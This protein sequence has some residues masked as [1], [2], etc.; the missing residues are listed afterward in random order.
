MWI[1]SSQT[2]S[3]FGDITYAVRLWALMANEGARM[4]HLRARSHFSL[5]LDEPDQ[6]CSH[7]DYSASI[8]YLNAPPFILA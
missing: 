8:C 2:Q 1:S 5:V 6:E 4:L 3:E 7:V